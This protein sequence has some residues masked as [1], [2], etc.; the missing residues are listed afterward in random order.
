MS[1]TELRDEEIVICRSCD[2]PFIGYEFGSNQA[3]RCAAEVVKNNIYGA[4]GSTEID[5]ERYQF[6]SRP[7]WIKDGTICDDCIVRL[8]VEMV[9]MKTESGVWFGEQN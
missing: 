3:H 5:G 4:Y 6:S 2:T 1:R 7:E 8:K 9:I